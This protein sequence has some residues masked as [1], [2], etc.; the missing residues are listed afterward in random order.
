MPNLKHLS[1]HQP[2]GKDY[3]G[4]GLYHRWSK[5]AEEAYLTDWR[6]IIWASNQTLETLVLEQQPG[7]ERETD[8]DEEVRFLL[9]DKD[10]LQSQSL[11]EMVEQL[12]AHEGSF[13]E[14]RRVFLYGIAV[15][16][17]SGGK[18]SHC[19]PGGRFM[20]F[21]ERRGGISCEARLGKWCQFD[22]A[23]GTAFAP[24]WT[25]ED[26]EYREEYEEETGLGIKWDTVLASI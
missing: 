1:L 17:E 20:Q 8:D 4:H 2:Y 11:L 23:D 25:G 16:E 19:T 3:Q 12:L 18:P 14:L 24:N 13:P 22:Y 7:A 15:G 26:D 5:P 10:G 21:L 6:R 9:E